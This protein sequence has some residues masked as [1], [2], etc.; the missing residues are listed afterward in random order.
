M[1]RQDTMVAFTAAVAM[2]GIVA[3]YAGKFLTAGTHAVVPRFREGVS[4]VALT[5]VQSQEVTPVPVRAPPRADVSQA[6]VSDRAPDVAIARLAIPK[7]APPEQ[8]IRSDADAD[9][10]EKGVRASAHAL[11]EIRP[12]YPMGARL[13][14]EEGIVAVRIHVAS[15]GVARDVRVVRSSGFKALDR[16]A[17]DAAGRAH[18]VTDDGQP[19]SDTD[20]EI[21]FRFKLT[22]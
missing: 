21:S 6:D 3:V 5:L 1:I 4:S 19:A 11:T 16:A 18:Y 22:D 15:G 10:Q 9:S 12:H 8:R 14:G 2:H 13:R 20:V 17:T 7:G